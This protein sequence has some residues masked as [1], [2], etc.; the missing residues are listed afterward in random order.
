MAR[1]KTLRSKRSRKNQTPRRSLRTKRTKRMK[2][3]KRTKRTKR[4]RRKRSHNKIGGAAAEDALGEPSDS[5]DGL[6]RAESWAAVGELAA[7]K[8]P[9]RLRNEAE[10]KLLRN[11]AQRQLAASALAESADDSLP[12]ISR[13]VAEL[14]LNEIWPR[15]VAATLKAT[16]E[17]MRPLNPDTPPKKLGIIVM[18]EMP[19]LITP[20]VDVHAAKKHIQRVFEDYDRAVRREA[21]FAADRLRAPEFDEDV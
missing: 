2:R 17:K 16:V 10:K 8:I 12:L 4:M 5:A 18:D 19:E 3:T 21:A 1:R 6:L 15:D 13:D 7:M 14:N 9:A 11:R 20:T